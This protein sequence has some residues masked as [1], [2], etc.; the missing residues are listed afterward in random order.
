MLDVGTVRVIGLVL[1]VLAV[2]GIATLARAVS[3]P[4]GRVL[5]SREPARGSEATWLGAIVLVQGWTLGVLL[6]PAWFYTWPSP[7]NFPD[8]T[9]VQL[10]GPALWLVGMGLVAWGTRTLGRYMTVAIQ[11]TEG[12]QL[13]QEGPYARIRHPIYT[14]NACAALGL[15]LLYLSPPLIALALVVVGLAMYRGQLEDEFLRSPEAF[16]ERYDAYVARTGR[17]LPRLRRS[18]P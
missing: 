8:A 2:V 18:R 14:G 13:V 11:V 3:R 15:A 12:H 5:A 9:D 16:G 7:G 17:F 10:V 6:L 1:L 4:R